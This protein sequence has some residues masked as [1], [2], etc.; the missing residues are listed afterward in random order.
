MTTRDRGAWLAI[1]ALL[2]LLLAIAWLSRHPDHPW[3]ARATAWPVVGGLAE[4]LRTAYTELRVIEVAGQDGPVAAGPAADRASAVPDATAG[5]PAAVEG[6]VE[7][8]REGDPALRNK[9]PPSDRR[10]RVWIGPATLLRSAPRE[11]AGL[12]V[13]RGHLEQ[14]PVAERRA[15]WI[16]VDLGQGGVAWL[17]AAEEDAPPLGSD[18]LPATPIAGREVTPVQRAR[19]H[20]LLGSALR[21]GRMG[22]YRMLTD[23]DAAT[24]PAGLDALATGLEAIYAARYARPPLPGGHETL[25]LCAR[26]ATFAALKGDEPALDPLPA[27][28]FVSGGLVVLDLEGRSAAEIART[29]VHEVAHLLNRRALGPSL[30][31]W[32][33]EGIADDLGLSEID[34]ER[35]TLRA[36]ALGS[37]VRMTGDTLVAGGAWAALVQARLGLAGR[38]SSDLVALFDRDW[39]TFVGADRRELDYAVSGLWVRFLLDGGD[40]RLRSGFQSFLAAVA[41]GDRGDAASLGRH[42]GGSW[43]LTFARF[44]L[45]LASE[46]ERLERAAV[47]AGRRLRSPAQPLDDGDVEAR[48]APRDGTGAGRPG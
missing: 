10:P 46:E 19:V 30:P 16:G 8:P 35:G 45:W 34:P 47:P 2:A 22:P 6:A 40:R 37:T 7:S 31:P 29:L 4:W 11:D 27:H 12:F 44:R 42:L 20:E 33:D 41:A 17:R 24:L 39:E 23:L 36:E 21:E 9:P 26:G 15:D 43:P 48:P 13:R 14:V 1:A 25:V 3:V 38:P 28:G 18:P 5:W 32:L